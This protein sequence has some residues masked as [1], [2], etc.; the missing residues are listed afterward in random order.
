V[1]FQ[2][3]VLERERILAGLSREELGAKADVATESIRL[4]ETGQVARPR[5]GTVRK[6]AKALRVPVELLWGING[7]AA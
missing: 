3:A 6:L 2:P 4:L 5:P 7:E 1:R